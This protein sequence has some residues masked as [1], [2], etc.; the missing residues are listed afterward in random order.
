MTLHHIMVWDPDWWGGQLQLANG[1]KK[2]SPSKYRINYNC[3]LLHIK[4]NW[5]QYP[6]IVVPTG[7]LR[8]TVHLLYSQFRTVS[9]YYVP[10]LAT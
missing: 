4:K 10:V 5:H 8:I 2:I 1:M 9:F 3:H 7:M 6:I